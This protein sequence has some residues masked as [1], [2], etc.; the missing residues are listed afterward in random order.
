MAP[1]AASCAPH[2]ANI[3]PSAWIVRHAPLAP[4]Q[5]PVLDL[6]CGNGRH[7]RMFLERGHRVLFLDRNVDPLA[8]LKNHERAE[9]R[10]ADLEDGSPWPLT[11]RTFGTIV[12]T[13]YLYR[14]LFPA[15]LDALAPGGLL[16]YETFACGQERFNR[17]RNPDHLLKCGE[18]LEWASKRL[19][20]VAYEH[21]QKTDG[22]L[23]GVVQRLCAVNDRPTDGT[24]PPVHLLGPL[25]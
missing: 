15:L 16:L 10:A 19:Q 9:I 24:E 25:P 21:G 6:A 8:D 5:G 12:V 20:V 22:P 7:G 17:P 18:L 4:Q 3:V 23:P 2:L 14:P 1:H 11:G 13:N